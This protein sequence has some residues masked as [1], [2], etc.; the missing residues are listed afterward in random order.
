MS[1]KIEQLAKEGEELLKEA[2]EKMHLKKKKKPFY[3]KGW[4]WLIILF[5]TAIIFVAIGY[6]QYWLPFRTVIAESN[7]AQ[8]HF[9]DAQREILQA[10]FKLASVS[11]EKAKNSLERVE[12]GVSSMGIIARLG[13]LSKQYQ[14]LKTIAISG[15]N[16]SSGLKTITQLSSQILSPL[17]EGGNRKFSQISLTERRQILNSIYKS[18]PDI[19]A[20][21]AEVE[22]AKI[23][24]D[25]LKTEGLHPLLK[26]YIKQMRI[27][28]DEVHQ[29]LV[30][31]AVMSRLL[32]TLLGYP[33]EKTYLFLLENNNELR[34]T[35]GFIGTIGVLKIKDA[36]ITSFKTTN[37]YD[38][39]KVSQGKMF[40]TAPKPITDYMNVDY[41]Y[42][43][44]SNWSPDFEI[45]AQKAIELFNWEASFSGAPFRQQNFDGVI[46]ITPEV[47]KDF[48]EISGAIEVEG[49]VFNADNFTERL[50]YLVEVGYEQ[51]GETYST[52]KNIIGALSEKL[53]NRF[54]NMELQKWISLMSVLQTN[55][56][57]KYILLNLTDSTLQQDIEQQVWAG[58][59]KDVEGDY[60][61]W[62][63]ANLAALKTDE[64][65]KRTITYQL[66][67]NNAG[68][69]LVKTSMVYENQG[70][71]TWK[72]TRYRT[73]ARL[74][75]PQ[76]SELIKTEG[77]MAADKTSLA[78][79][80][81][82]YSE[83]G[84]TVFG[85]FIS[86]EPGERG[87]LSFEYKL[88]TYVKERLENKQYSLTL[89]KQA[90]TIAHN[91]I[92]DLIFKNEITSASPAEDKQN[93]GD[94]RYQI[95]TDLAE[96]KDFIVNF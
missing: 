56:N 95:T 45:S 23:Q 29:N 40:V 67:E 89:Q 92:I 52:R 55:L 13:P 63:D 35:G 83:L 31:A 81:D 75:V 79:E 54:E 72:S 26:S 22:L 33:E 61:M 37:V 17:E 71:F 94:R 16:L 50:E 91:L 44:D 36:K 93:W 88:P 9:I 84:K 58:K 7:K 48:L 8:I 12:A 24:L 90:G 27:K 32:P 74:Y 96:D 47:I 60:L 62:I 64:F 77:S 14:A 76:G 57:K 18:A 43:R 4:L 30:K 73:Y 69:L 59:V 49:F 65:M 11:L 80:T 34:P 20:A 82:V 6:F 41:L 86:I 1:S 78:G 42:L 46:A 19:Q 28:L 5:F 3:K 25:N 68:E 85:A 10:D 15:Q 53:M 70:S 21:K 2:E 51:V 39:D 66:V 87:T 38:L